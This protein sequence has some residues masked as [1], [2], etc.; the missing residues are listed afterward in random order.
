[1]SD[2][3]TI[4]HPAK[5]EEEYLAFAKQVI[6]DASQWAEAD[7]LERRQQE[8]VVFSDGSLSTEESEVAFFWPLLTNHYGDDLWGT[9][10]AER[11]AMTHLAHGIIQPPKLSRSDGTR[12]VEPTFE[13]MRSFVVIDL[14][15][16]LVEAFERHD[17]LKLTE[18]QILATYHAARS[19]WTASEFE[20]QLLIPIS[21][22]TSDVDLS[23][24]GEDLQLSPF[25]NDEKTKAWWFGVFPFF[26]APNAWELHGCDYKLIV[27]K[28]LPRGER[29]DQQSID[30]DVRMFVLALRLFKPG[31]VGTLG[32]FGGAPGDVARS[33]G[34]PS[35]SYVYR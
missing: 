15:R 13:Q 4:D 34:W 16:P 17:T 22:L 30:L 31:E 7:G 32:S 9:P 20:H 1:M 27:Q 6:Q 21:G 2:Q 25:T 29:L 5:A 35:S 3:G 24:V 23:R 12:I 18:G 19:S 10:E 33:Y 8:R 26:R 14:L 11:C 28:T